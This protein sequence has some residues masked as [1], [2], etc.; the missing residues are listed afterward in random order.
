MRQLKRDVEQLAAQVRGQLAP[1]FTVV[2]ID[3]VDASNPRGPSLPTVGYRCDFRIGIFACRLWLPAADAAQIIEAM[4][5]QW[6]GDGFP[7]AVVMLSADTPPDGFWRV[8]VREPGQSIAEH[9]CAILASMDV[10]L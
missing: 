9:A 5:E 7:S 8:P 3:V 1:E 2:A 10:G 6:P 4:R